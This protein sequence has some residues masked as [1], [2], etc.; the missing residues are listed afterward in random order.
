MSI[1][2]QIER[3]QIACSLQAP[4]PVSRGGQRLPGPE[5]SLHL[6]EGAP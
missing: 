1:S 5:F 3:L 2:R 6:Q 4:A